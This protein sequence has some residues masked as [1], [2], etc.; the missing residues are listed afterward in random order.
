MSPARTIHCPE[1]EKRLAPGVSICKSCADAAIA[2]DRDH[3]AEVE[4][5]RTKARQIGERAAA[6]R[7]QQ[8]RDDMVDAQIAAKFDPKHTLPLAYGTPL[9]FADTGNAK[10]H[11]LGHPPHLPIARSVQDVQVRALADAIATRESYLLQLENSDSWDR[12]EIQWHISQVVNQ[13]RALTALLIE[14]GVVRP[15]NKCHREYLEGVAVKASTVKARR[16]KPGA[17]QP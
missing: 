13:Y 2:R 14:P 11:P 9:R 1:C 17:Q 6:A 10:G 15:N 7:R 12:D 3:A 4:G 8:Q 16:S 5:L